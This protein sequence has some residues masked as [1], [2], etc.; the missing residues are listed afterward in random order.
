MK[1]LSILAIAVLALSFA[2]CKKDRTCTCTNTSTTTGPSG[3]TTT[4]DASAA[5][6]TKVSKKAGRV[7]C[8]STKSTSSQTIGGD[9]YTTVSENNCT[10]S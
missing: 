5:T 4:T 10:L 6:F 9:T 2:S 7:N 1:K 8:L 3:S